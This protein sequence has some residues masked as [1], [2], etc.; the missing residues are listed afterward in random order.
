[1]KETVAC[2]QCGAEA[3]VVHLEHIEG[4]DHG[5]QVG[6]DGLAIYECEHGHKRLASPEYPVRF[7]DS[8][9][10]ADDIPP[11]KPAEK[12]GLFRK[13]LHCTNCGEELPHD[14]S[15]D[16][17]AKRTVSV[18]EADPVDVEVRM[19]VYLCS[20]C[21]SRATVPPDE[22]QKELVAAI[23]AGFRQAG[24]APG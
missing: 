5:I 20:K 23:E 7:I 15:G 22:V 16:E 2:R 8:L 13:H 17:C 9:M 19:P 24:V 1:M 12:K 14:A 11:V 4:E 21:G 10:K 6:M 18:E 3:H